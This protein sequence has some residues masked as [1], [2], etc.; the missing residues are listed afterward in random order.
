MILVFILIYC[1][2]CYKTIPVK[3]EEKWWEKGGIWIKASGY[4]NW[5]RIKYVT[6]DSV[7][8]EIDLGLS[9]PAYKQ[10]VIPLDSV[11]AIERKKIDPLRSVFG[12]TLFAG[13]L[14]SVIYIIQFS[15]ITLD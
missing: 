9:R 7:Y 10:V 4:K 14:L 12:I 5:I 15:N 1:T 6:E 13:V 3:E 2:S 11:E 8:G